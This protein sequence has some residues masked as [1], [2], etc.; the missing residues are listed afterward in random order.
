MIQVNQST[1]S[2]TEDGRTDLP[3][4]TFELVTGAGIIARLK[5]EADGTCYGI[6]VNAEH[7]RKGHATT[8]WRYAQANGY[9]PKHSA[10][11][12]VDG[13]AWAASLNEPLPELIT[14]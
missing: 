3:I 13:Q 4:T 12:T 11:R 9:A 14:V 6:W 7:R 5:L 2:Y 8:L 10:E 1:I